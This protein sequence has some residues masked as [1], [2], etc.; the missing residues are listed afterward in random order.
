MMAL[1]FLALGGLFSASAAQVPSCTHQPNNPVQIQWSESKELQSP[2]CRWSIEVR[3]LKR[4]DGPASVYL[5][6]RAGGAERLL[7]RLNRDGVIHWR[8]D[9]ESLVVEDM[10]FSNSYRLLLFDMAKPESEPD[11]LKINNEIRA[12]VEHELKPGEKINYYFPRFVAWA[13]S[14]LVVSVGLTTVNGQTGPF[15]PHCFGYGVATQSPKISTTL[16]E[17]DLK[18]Q[19]G[20][21]CQIFP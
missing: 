18:K 4:A 10:R 19:Y 12:D 6:N 9:G 15:A 17:D 3:P 16:T 11:A 2:D 20:A 13:G 5:K 8:E 21:S 7:F 1:L 14:G